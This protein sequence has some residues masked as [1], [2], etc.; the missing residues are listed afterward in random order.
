MTEDGAAAAPAEAAPKAQPPQ[1][2]K[3]WPAPKTL[4]K[5]LMVATKD[6]DPGALYL[7]RILNVNPAYGK[8]LVCDEELAELVQAFS[9]KLRSKIAS[10]QHSDVTSLYEPLCELVWRV[11][12]HIFHT[13]IELQENRDL[14]VPQMALGQVKMLL[15]TNEE[16][17]RQ[18]KENRR[19]YLKELVLLREKSRT[20]SAQAQAAVD[21]L[22]DDP[23]MFYEPLSYVLDDA[24]KDFVRE[25]IEERLKLEMRRPKEEVEV[26]EEGKEEEEFDEE[27]IRA[28]QAENRALRQQVSREGERARRA[29]DSEVRL[30]DEVSKLNAEVAKLR[31]ELQDANGAVDNLKGEVSSQ[32]QQQSQAS[33]AAA[34]KKGR[35]RDTSLEDE[36]EEL[37]KHLDASLEENLRLNEEL[38][39]LRKEKQDQADQMKE[40]KSALNAG[41]DE[42]RKFK[43]RKAK[44]EEEESKGKKVRP[45][46]DDS[47]LREQLEEYMRLEKELRAEIKRLETAL[48]NAGGVTKVVRK[49]A[50]KEEPEEPDTVKK[51]KNKG[52]YSEDEL[53]QAVN[54]AKEKMKKKIDRL[55]AEL[56]Q[57]N[58]DLEDARAKI[59]AMEKEAKER[60]AA[61]AAMGGEGMQAYQWKQKYEDLL[62]KYEDLMTRYEA[63]E[64]KVHLLLDKLRQYGG[65]SAV[66]ATLE[67]I[68]LD[69]PPGKKGRKL[70][71]WERLW[72][73]ASRRIGQFRERQQKLKEEEEQYITR[74]KKLLTGKPQSKQVDALSRLHKAHVKTGAEF[75][76]AF[77]EFQQQ[78][79]DVMATVAEGDEEFGGGGARLCPHCGKDLDSLRGTLES[80]PSFSGSNFT[81]LLLQ[82]SPGATLTSTFTGEVGDGP[83]L[84]SR[85]LIPSRSVEDFGQPEEEPQGPEGLVVRG[86]RSPAYSRSAS[87]SRS[88]SVNRR[89]SASPFAATAPASMRVSTGD[90][91]ASASQQALLS[92]VRL[93]GGSVPAVATAD[94][95]ENTPPAQ[96]AEQE[97]AAKEAPLGLS[98]QQLSSTGAAQAAPASSP[99]AS[100]APQ[101]ERSSAPLQGSGGYQGLLLS[102]K[103]AGQPTSPQY[104]RS[105][106]PTQKDLN[107]FDRDSTPPALQELHRQQTVDSRG[108]GALAGSSQQ[109]MDS[110]LRRPVDMKLPTPPPGWH[111]NPMSATTPSAAAAAGMAAAAQQPVV[112]GRMPS[113][114]RLEPIQNSG[115]FVTGLVGAGEREQQQKGRSRSPTPLHQSSVELACHPPPPPA[116]HRRVLSS[117]RGKRGHEASAPDLRLGNTISG[118]SAS[119]KAPAQTQSMMRDTAS[120]SLPSLHNAGREIASSGPARALQQQQQHQQ[121]QQK[122]RLTKSGSGPLAGLDIPGQKFFVTPLVSQ[123]SM[124]AGLAPPMPIPP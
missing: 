4:E 102:S 17:S 69:P 124:A 32:S 116:A 115:M 87:S 11:V 65:E 76:E 60:E 12:G 103:A 113:R 41:D 77:S 66:S 51:P 49:R 29:E 38:D 2:Q 59:K 79:P 106:S 108:S 63:L 55:E 52:G 9:K 95:Q 72:N 24:T 121:Q 101:V 83:F 73:D 50:A 23:V 56:E 30:K 42:R 85:R 78:N 58:A 96:P 88:V 37:R 21:S 16:L 82:P 34:K 86:R 118:V 35:E 117:P 97:A 111:H 40:L 36:L 15:K 81:G 90:S 8:Y 119:M 1:N 70:K 54:E 46:K 122:M 105:R 47:E 27:F 98:V 89:R 62:K 114:G 94:G 74:L 107:Q 10:G 71:A 99:Q 48:E 109:A 19:A 68:Q 92:T 93:G 75:H 25:V 110:S 104:G 91:T 20:I 7:R 5:W 31:S 80:R 6:A 14:P 39:R 64:H 45:A 44:E 28:M 120:R 13:M 112:Q 18:L 22:Q 61:L 123:Q 84:Q 33:A 3:T 43:E 57:A 53:R 100:P 67:Q 26:R